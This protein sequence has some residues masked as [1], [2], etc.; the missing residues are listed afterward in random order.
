MCNQLLRR[1]KRNSGECNMR[2]DGDQS[3]D[4]FVTHENTGLNLIC[5]HVIEFL[6]I[7]PFTV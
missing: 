3:V 4:S 2:A 1:F 5:L 7:Q 6:T